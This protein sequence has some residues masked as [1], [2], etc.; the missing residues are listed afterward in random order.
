MNRRELITTAAAALAATIYKD[1][2]VQA[3]TS[4]GKP[5]TIYKLRWVPTAPSA[6]EG[7]PPS[8]RYWWPSDPA[9][10]DMWLE[11]LKSGGRQ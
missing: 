10:N 3:A 8:T 2:T 6:S 11:A 7:A 9:L 4:T 5:P 1:G